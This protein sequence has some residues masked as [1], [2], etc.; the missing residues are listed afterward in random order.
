MFKGF[1]NIIFVFKVHAL[2]I[3]FLFLCLFGI[4][5]LNAQ[6][7]QSTINLT[8]GKARQIAIAANTDISLKNM[9][10]LIAEE[11]VK[12][13]KKGVNPEVFIDFN[14]QRNLII[15]STP[16]PAKAFNPNAQ[17]GDLLLLKFS[18]NWSGNAGINFNYDL[19]NPE[20]KSKVRQSEIQS[21]I[22]ITDT[23]LTKTEAILNISKTYMEA[24]IAQEQLKLNIADFK[25]K[26]TIYNMLS[27]QHNAGRITRIE[28]NTGK[29]ALNTSVS[30][31]KEA[32]NIAD[33]ANAELLYIM[34]YNPLDPIH[35]DFEDSIDM[36]FANY[37]TPRQNDSLPLELQKLEQQKM[38]LEEEKLA[39]KVKYYPKLSLGAFYG[40]NYYDNQFDLFKGTNWHGNSFVKIGLKIPLT[41]WMQYKNDK[42]IINYQINSNDLAYK[43]KK[44]QVALNYLKASKD[45]DLNKGKY[46]DLKRNFLLEQE[47]YLLI[48]QQYTDGR[49]LIEELSKA[50]YA[51]QFAKSEYL[52]A[53][54]N[55]LLA[56]LQMEYEQS[57]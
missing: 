57:K 13:S 42:A 20:Q 52:N 56:E 4:T 18:T 38:L 54:Y 48:Q 43:N 22:A 9:D 53:A 1:S 50:D 8:L 5:N 6:T 32:Q 16:V 14:L 11:A 33:K 49:L 51:V 30:K 12:Q 31:N 17:E 27:D 21:K 15:P 23:K 47:N 19:F 25:T 7:E 37:N 36:L 29:A 26:S 35:I 44:N 34:G 45:I 55:Y 24:L 46:E 28:L 2:S 39:A 41:D 10:A 40:N 3:T